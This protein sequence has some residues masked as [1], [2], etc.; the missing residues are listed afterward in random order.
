ME[1]LRKATSVDI[2]QSMVDF[3]IPDEAK[4][5]MIKEKKLT[6]AVIRAY[7]KES[8]D[9]LRDVKGNCKRFISFVN[10]YNDF[11]NGKDVYIKY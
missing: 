4:R 5:M 1:Y 2:V 3:K 11:I 6:P 9:S 7:R 8:Y 10:A